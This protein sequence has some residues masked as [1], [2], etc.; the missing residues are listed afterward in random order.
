MKQQSV[1]DMIKDVRTILEENVSATPLEGVNDIGTLSINSVIEGVLTKAVTA[2]AKIA[3]MELF[4]EP[5]YRGLTNTEN[6][7]VRVPANG[8][9]I[10]I[11]FITSQ[12]IRGEISGREDIPVAISQD[13]VV[14]VNIPATQEDPECYDLKLTDQARKQIMID[15]VQSEEYKS[16][17]YE[18]GLMVLPSKNTN[19]VFAFR[20]SDYLRTLYIEGRGWERPVLEVSPLN[21][22]YVSIARSGVNL[23]IGNK[24]KPLVVASFVNGRSAFEFYPNTDKINIVYIENPKIQGTSEKTINCDDGILHASEYY[25]AYLVAM[26]KGYQ[27]A[28]AY[29]NAAIEALASNA[30]PTT[31]A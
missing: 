15:I 5:S 13:G 8:G 16:V 22:P 6:G 18:L 20:P 11:P 27:N 14:S 29:K 25:A 9:K 4:D 7:I 23:S 28:E 24:E 21:S 17:I 3:P 10:E 19:G 2:V 26:I 12:I 30:S 31:N 1:T